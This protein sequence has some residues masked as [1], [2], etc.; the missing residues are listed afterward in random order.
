MKQSEM[1]VSVMVVDGE[2]K[3]C[4]P[5]NPKDLKQ[6]FVIYVINNNNMV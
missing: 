2:F 1:R 6:I 4:F 5:I 3:Q